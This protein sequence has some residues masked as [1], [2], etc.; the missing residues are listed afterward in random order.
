[1]SPP[2]L[3]SLFLFFSSVI[4]DRAFKFL[5]LLFKPS[6]HKADSLFALFSS[7]LYP[8]E[9]IQNFLF[10][11]FC[12]ES[13]QFAKLRQTA[14][15]PTSSSPPTSCD[16]PST[17]SLSLLSPTS[18]KDKIF[19]SGRPILRVAPSQQKPQRNLH[20]QRYHTLFSIDVFHPS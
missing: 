9:H 7:V 1:M 16:S 13:K 12:Q 19:L 5:Q 17:T 11:S 4:I 8:L 15:F 14:I 10:K 20:S 6:R 2:L 18:I 3:Y